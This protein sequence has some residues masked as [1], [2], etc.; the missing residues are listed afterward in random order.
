M[1][2]RH[3]TRPKNKI[4][5]FIHSNRVQQIATSQYLRKCGVSQH[6]PVS[7]LL[8]PRARMREAGLRLRDPRAVGVARQFVQAHFSRTESMLV[9]SNFLDTKQGW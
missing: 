3:V 8:L 6:P 9:K 5:S 4:H 2:C 7:S 1:A